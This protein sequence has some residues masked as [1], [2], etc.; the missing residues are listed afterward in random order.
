MEN[1]DWFYIFEIKEVE[2]INFGDLISVEATPINFSRRNNGSYIK[3]I[4]ESKKD[5]YYFF[6]P[7]E[8]QYI[9]NIL[10][11]AKSSMGEWK[12]N[13]EEFDF[14]VIELDNIR[15][16]AYYHKSIKNKKSIWQS[17]KSFIKK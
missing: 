3:S 12:V 8:K 15:T 2:D 9:D 1:C 14:K 13:F 7:K 17:I 4:S 5:R 11:I 6:Y 10:H 16:S